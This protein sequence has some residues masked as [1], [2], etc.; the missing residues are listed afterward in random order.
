[1]MAPLVVKKTKPDAHEKASVC[2]LYIRRRL[3]C[4]SEMHKINCRACELNEF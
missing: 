1:M 3:V 2:A 4:I